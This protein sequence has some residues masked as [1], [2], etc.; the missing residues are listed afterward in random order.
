[1]ETIILQETDPA[2]LEIITV[3]LQMENFNV[4]AVLDPGSN[5]LELIDELR[6]H[7]IMLD[8]R[9]NGDSCVKICKEI[10][11]RYP[12]LPVIALSCNHNIHDEYNKYGFDDYIPKP[13]DLDNLYAILRK[14][15]PNQF[16]KARVIETLKK[17]IEK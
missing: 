7:V 5:F 12:H 2:I 13:F 8:Y 6:P 4:Y 1:M 3:A 14:Y 10:K 16:S 9:L 17:A 11:A 15:I